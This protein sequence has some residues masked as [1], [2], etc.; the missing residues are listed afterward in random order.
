M[1]VSSETNLNVQFPENI[2]PGY[3]FYACH[4]PDGNIIE[5]NRSGGVWIFYKEYLPLRI[6]QDLSFAE[7]I[8]SELIYAH[9]IILSR[10]I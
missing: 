8:V 3:K 6:R 1:N 10:Y 4:H 9:K 7:C 2:L 5:Y